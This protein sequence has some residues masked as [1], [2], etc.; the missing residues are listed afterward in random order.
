MQEKNLA[1]Q[2]YNP[3]H[4]ITPISD[5]VFNIAEPFQLKFSLNYDGGGDTVIAKLSGNPKRTGIKIDSVVHEPDGTYSIVFYGTPREINKN[6]LVLTVRD[7]RD[8]IVKFP[9]TFQ[10]NPVKIEDLNLPDATALFTPYT[11]KIY[12]KFPENFKED[13]KPKFGFNFPVEFGF[14]KNEDRDGVI[15]GQDEIG[16]FTT[17]TFNPSKPGKYKFQVDILSPDNILLGYRTMRL[18][19]FESLAKKIKS[20]SR[21]KIIDEGPKVEVKA[22]DINDWK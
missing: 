5:F 6:D 4:F 2:I 17:I 9:I 10:V 14:V 19:V 11:A 15:L 16:K 7:N 20:E 18:E 21:K 22:V 13:I 12:Y 8:N 3:F 1:G